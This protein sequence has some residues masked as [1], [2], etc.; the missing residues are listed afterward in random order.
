MELFSRIGGAAARNVML[1]GA[2][3]LLLTMCQTGETASRSLTPAEME[4]KKEGVDVAKLLAMEFADA[5]KISP[6][7][8]E[9]PPFYKITADQISVLKKDSK[10]RPQRV[11]AK[12]RVFVQIDFRDKLVA[13][14]QEAYI[15]SDGEVILRGRPLLKR[16]RTVVEGLSETTVYYIKG[17]RLQ[18]LGSHRMAKQEG[19]ITSPHGGTF[20]PSYDVQPS[21][22]RA[23]RDGPS[24]LLPALSP[25]DLPAD[26][27]AS[28]LLPPSQGSSDL[29]QLLVPGEDP[30]PPSRPLGRRNAAPKP[31]DPPQP[32]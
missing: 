31:E 14:A 10:G 20:R 26:M 16:G 15:E 11:R 19:G 23:W 3:C 12:G 18:V 32:E 13:L 17:T 9:V 4:D 22:R 21:W 27:R 29:P 25:N 7:S 5:K 1:A 8:L 28:P 24:P 2:G 30:V 6:N